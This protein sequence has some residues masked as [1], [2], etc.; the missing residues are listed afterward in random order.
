MKLTRKTSSTPF[1]SS[2]PPE[3]HTPM[4]SNFIFKRATLIH[5][6]VALIGS[7]NILNASAAVNSGSTGADGAFAPTANIQV[8]LPASGVF[9]YTT[10]NIPSGVTV[11][12]L[13]NSANTPV[14]IL[15][16]GDVTVAGV[17]DISGK[18]AAASGAAGSGLIADDGSPGVGGPGGY[19]GGRGGKSPLGQGGS[20]VGPGGGGGGKYLMASSFYRPGGGGAGY[21]TV[22]TLSYMRISFTSNTAAGGDAGLAYGAAQLLPLIGGSGGGGGSGGDFFGASGGGGGGGAILLASSGTLNITGTINASGALGGTTDGLGAGG[23]G[24]S[25]SGGG[26]RLVATT[27]SGNGNLFARSAASAPALA[28]SSSSG[29]GGN[30]SVGRIRLE[31]ETITRTAASDPAHSFGAPGPLFIAGQPTV[32]IKTVAGT[33]VPANPTGVGDVQ[34][35]S[36]IMNP[37][38][39]EFETTGVPVGNIVKLVVTPAA[40][41]VVTGFSNALSG[42]TALANSTVNVALPQGASVLQAI[43][44]YT[45]T[46]AMGDAL[47]QFA[48]NERV[49]AVT[50]TAGLN[51]PGAASF[52]TVSGKK[53]PAPKEALTLLALALR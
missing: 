11:T 44:T 48:N 12:Y 33:A 17:I 51:G 21:A 18:A 30:S 24:G 38:T 2:T 20:G 53:F 8:T 27:I 6:A 25:G 43:L 47:S 1:T 42:S 36:T 41:D 14:T 29:Y 22:G 16:S 3:H 28:G 7:L 15:A 13:K 4:K 10:V 19:D 35:P 45:I 23:A 37:V 34:L 9:N 46:V 49:E 40:S 26:I 39:V 5:A 32:R 52:T 31:A 50:L